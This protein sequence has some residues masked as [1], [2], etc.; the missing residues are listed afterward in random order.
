MM[1][2]LSTLA[3]LAGGAW[4]ALRSSRGVGERCPARQGMEPPSDHDWLYGPQPDADDLG[5]WDRQ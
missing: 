4:L 3:I 2:L 5:G 1:G